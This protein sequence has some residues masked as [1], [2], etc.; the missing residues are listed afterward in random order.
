[1]NQSDFGLMIGVTQVYMSYLEKGV[2]QPGKTLKLFLDCL[3]RE[4]E[5]KKKGGK[6]NGSISGMPN[7]PQ[8]A[9]CK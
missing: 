2:R 7:L 4:H 9:K 8:K 5:R 3:E 1:M 6:K